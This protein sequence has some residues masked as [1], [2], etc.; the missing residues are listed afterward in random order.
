FIAKCRDLFGTSIEDIDIEAEEVFTEYTWPGNVRELEH[1]IESI[2]ILAG[3]NEKIITVRHLPE[4]MLA[5]VKLAEK[6]TLH[7]P[8]QPKQIDL[9]SLMDDYERATILTALKESRGNISA[10]ARNLN[11]HRN[12]LYSK[13]KRLNINIDK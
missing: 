5:S 13:I 11:I 4:Q 9:N 10:A 1:L 8:K 12:A 3:E 6:K 7:T 2:A